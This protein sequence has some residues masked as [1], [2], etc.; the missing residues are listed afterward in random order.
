ME[1]LFYLY[2]YFTSISAVEPRLFVIS[3]CARLGFQ[4]VPA[5]LVV[6]LV[7]WGPHSPTPL[8]QPSTHP[9]GERGASRHLY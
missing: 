7:A 3:S 4:I 9:A 1:I 5:G 2:T 6:G 8:S